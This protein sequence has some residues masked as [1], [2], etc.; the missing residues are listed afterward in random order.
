M[1]PSYWM[2]SLV[3]S[4]VLDVIGNY[5][6]D[7]VHVVHVRVPLKVGNLKPNVLHGMLHALSML[8]S[9]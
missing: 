1:T 4:W 5:V 6:L 7:T 9:V 2:R 8:L 3:S